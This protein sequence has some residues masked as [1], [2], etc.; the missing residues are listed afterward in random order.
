M[1]IKPN[2]ELDS[3][4]SYGIYNASLTGYGT[5]RFY[6]RFSSNNR[7]P[8]IFVY[9]D[10]AYK[11]GMTLGYVKM[12]RL[13]ADPKMAIEKHPIYKMD[14]IDFYDRYAWEI[15]GN[16]NVIMTIAMGAASSGWSGG[17]MIWPKNLPLTRLPDT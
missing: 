4:L 10:Q 15:D 16:N 14:D 3:K 11:I 1:V 13:D 2:N 5:L 12:I 17:F 7:F 8:F 9:S 6:F